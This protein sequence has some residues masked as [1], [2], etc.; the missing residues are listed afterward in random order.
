MSDIY[1]SNLQFFCYNNNIKC[2]VMEFDPKFVSLS[3]FNLLLMKLNYISL[4]NY[5]IITG[6]PI[7]FNT[8]NIYLL[9]TNRW[10]SFGRWNNKFHR[11]IELTGFLPC[12]T[13][14]RTKRSIR[15]LYGVLR[16]WCISTICRSATRLRS[17]G[18]DAKTAIAKQSTGTSSW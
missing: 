12:A 3:I 14:R 8:Y 10:W 6:H 1:I 9:P 13:W 17:S 16:C 15:W 7:Y 2:L 4:I 5:I 11:V 18:S